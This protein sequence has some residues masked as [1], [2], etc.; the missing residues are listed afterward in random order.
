[1]PTSE[2]RHLPPEAR[3]HEPRAALDGGPDGLDVIR[4]V[5]AC[6]PSW[7]RPGGALVVET[8]SAQAPVAAAAFAGAGLRPRVVDEE[9]G[10][11]VV[12]VSTGRI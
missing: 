10:T 3:K 2:L 8:S 4:R 5:A 1:M 7:L 11:V 6:A 9:T 12:G